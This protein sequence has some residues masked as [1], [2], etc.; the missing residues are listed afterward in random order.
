MAEQVGGPDYLDLSLTDFLDRTAAAT[1]APGA[2]AAVATAVALA[3]GLAAMSAGLSKRHLPEADDVAA[4]AQELQARV[5]PLA[6]RDAEIYGEVLRARA[7]DRDDPGRPDAVREAL[8]RAADVPLEMAEVAAEVF[9]LAAAVVRRGNPAL[10]GDA[11]T[12][13]LLSQAGVR[14]AAV[15]VELNLPDPDD[16]RR[17]RAAELVSAVEDAG[18]PARE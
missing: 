3:A 18:K 13:C 7:L 2:G 11:L 8:S 6:Q 9:G 1:A 5:K 12:S 15:L 4:R 10:E 14:A 16:P 17:A